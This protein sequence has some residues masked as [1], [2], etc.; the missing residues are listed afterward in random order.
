MSVPKSNILWLLDGGWRAATRTAAPGRTTAAEPARLD[1]FPCSH[2][3]FSYGSVISA[4]NITF[5]A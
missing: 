1:S 5:L 2:F 3:S 4:V